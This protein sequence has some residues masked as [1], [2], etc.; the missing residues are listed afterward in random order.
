MA[1]P[2]RPPLRRGQPRRG[3]ACVRRRG[4]GLRRGVVYGAW[5]GSRSGWAG[6]GAGA[7]GPARSP[8]AGERA[9]APAAGARQPRRGSQAGPRREAGGVRGPCG[10]AVRCALPRGATPNLP[11]RR[12]PALLFSSPVSFPRSSRPA[13]PPRRAFVPFGCARSLLSP[14]LASPRGP[15]RRCFPPVSPRRPPHGRAAGAL[16]SPLSLTRP[17][18][19]NLPTLDLPETPPP[20][21]PLSAVGCCLDSQPCLS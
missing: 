2:C 16:R 13:S 1:A 15:R 21:Q 17:C 3:P 12:V 11:T 4:R 5:R 19:L 14:P 6:L 8:R 20:A 9:E 7:A 10:E 18:P